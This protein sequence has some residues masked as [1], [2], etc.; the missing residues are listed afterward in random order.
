MKLTAA[1]VQ[2][3]MYRLRCTAERDL[4][5]R[6]ANAA[7]QLA[8]ELETPNRVTTLT[9]L[10]RQLIRYAVAKN[11]LPLRQENFATVA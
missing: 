1:Q 7:S 3:I 9:E 8:F 10:D 2:Q 5:D 4:N 6:I 11:Y